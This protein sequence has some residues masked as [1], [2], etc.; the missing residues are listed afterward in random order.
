LKRKKY[1]T[2]LADEQDLQELK[3]LEKKIKKQ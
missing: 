2:Q 3:E 1:D